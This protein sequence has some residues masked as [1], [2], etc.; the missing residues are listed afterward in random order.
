MI[1]FIKHITTEGPETLGEFFKKQKFPTKIIE[2]GN[3]GSLPKD[4]NYIDAVISLGGP[5]NVYEEQKNPFLKKEDDFI[6][7]VLI[8]EIPF[9]GICLGSQ[10]LAKA[11][12]GKVIK[13]PNEEIGFFKVQFTEEGKC[14]NLFAGISPEITVFQ[15]HEDMFLPSVKANLLARSERCPNQAFK[16]GK[17]AYGL[18]FHVEVTGETIANWADDYLPKNIELSR[19]KKQEMLDSYNKSKSEFDSEAFKIYTNFLNIIKNNK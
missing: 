6:R 14:D 7:E 19:I 3:G 1:L 10:L 8:R 15:W 17:C 2:L 11:S 4:F 13:S 9:L 12:G 16:I 5:M 18:Q